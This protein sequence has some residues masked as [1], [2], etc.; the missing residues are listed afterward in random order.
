MCFVPPK[1]PISYSLFPYFPGGTVATMWLTVGWAVKLLTCQTTQSSATST[2]AGLTTARHIGI[3]YTYSNFQDFCWVIFV[4]ISNIYHI[5]NIN[6][7]R[8]RITKLSGT[9]VRLTYL[10]KRVC[11]STCNRTTS[12]AKGRTVDIITFVSKNK[13]KFRIKRTVWRYILHMYKNLNEERTFCKAQKLV[14]LPVPGEN[15]CSN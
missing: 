1:D 13:T 9:Q 8:T 6:T 5:W 2:T 10:G 11:L 7:K 4:D 14:T 15:W 12:R 3:H